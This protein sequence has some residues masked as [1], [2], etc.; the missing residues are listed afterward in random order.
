MLFLVCSK[1]EGSQLGV[2]WSNLTDGDFPFGLSLLILLL[3]IFIYTALAWYLDQV[4]D[5]I[6]IYTYIYIC[7][8]IDHS[9]FLAAGL[10]H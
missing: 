10:L 1:Y 3:D 6:Y 2:T 9:R 5:S 8:Y 7:I 4:R